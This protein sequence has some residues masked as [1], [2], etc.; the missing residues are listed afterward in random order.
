MRRLLGVAL[1]VLAISC[2]QDQLT[3][4]GTSTVGPAGRTPAAAAMTL[5]PPIT[6]LAPTTFIRGTGKPE[7]DTASFTVPQGDTVTYILSSNS[8]Q[9]L[10]VVVSINGGSGLRVNG[11]T[12]LPDTIELPGLPT[13][14]VTVQSTGKPGSSL[15]ITATVPAV[16]RFSATGNIGLNGGSVSLSTGTVVTFPAGAY[17]NG[18]LASVTE[19][20][21]NNNVVDDPNRT[22]SISMHGA[23]A[24]DTGFVHTSV[25]WPMP[26]QTGGGVYLPEYRRTGDP[27]L[28]FPQIVT[29]GSNDLRVNRSISSENAWTLASVVL[30]IAQAADAPAEGA[31]FL[32][33][34]ALAPAETEAACEADGAYAFGPAPGTTPQPNA[35]GA[36]VLIHGLELTRTCSGAQLGNRF[37]TDFDPYSDYWQPLVADFADRPDLNVYVYR[38]P[39]TLDPLVNAQHLQKFLNDIVVPKLSSASQRIVLVGYSMGGLVARGVDHLD[40]AHLLR[41]IVTIGTPHFGSDMADLGDALLP[42]AGVASLRPNAFNNRF[43]LPTSASLFAIR[44]GL[45]CLP[46]VE[47]QESAEDGT[48]PDGFGHLDNWL[49]INNYLKCEAKYGTYVRQQQLGV[50]DGVVADTSAIPS[51]YAD[52]SQSY[53]AERLVGSPLVYITHLHL[54][55]NLDIASH[56]AARVET[57]LPN[58]GK[59]LLYSD[60]FSHGLGNWVDD[61]QGSWTTLDNELI[62]DY[63]IGCGSP[64]CPQT[65]LLLADQFQPG[66]HNWRMEIQANLVE[67]Y[68]CYNGGADVSFAK[69]SIYTSANE[70]DDFEVGRGWGPE[71]TLVPTADHVYAGYQSYA[72]WQSPGNADVAVSPWQTNE[73]Q[74]A[75]L[76]KRGNQ[77][78]LYWNGVAV[79]TTTRIHSGVPKV[80]LHTYGKVRM[81]NFKLYLLP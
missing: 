28:Y 17:L 76:E 52:P 75:A 5:G 15:T 50:S 56:T 35:S 59:R 73:W 11:S 44:G 67:A 8:S 26:A 55:Q 45:P 54:P 77:Y 48:M 3:V 23:A 66:D 7:P 81:D 37:D 27:T 30:S 64:S 51:A 63:N 2:T 74:T 40:A 79:Y 78:T 43:P 22:L 69:F 33:R 1:F 60:D 25:S 29:A 36:V 12:S 42:S 65:D 6:V 14:G 53:V 41:G 72:P 10:D 9:G 18:T 70:K 16:E 31:V 32:L 80:G 49:F 58:T 39:T 20:R 34:M 61:G 24:F 57:W 19:T 46:G 21:P 62:G 13:N 47:I 4:P 71:N 38:Y 68:C